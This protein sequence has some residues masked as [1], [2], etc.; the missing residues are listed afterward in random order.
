[1]HYID[2][3]VRAEIIEASG[4]DIVARNIQRGREQGVSGYNTWREI[5]G[6][7]PIKSFNKFGKFGNALKE[8]YNEPDDVDLFIGAML[9]KDAGFNVG[10]TFQ[11]LLG[12][13][14]QRIK[15]GDRFW[16]ERPC[17]IF[18]FTEG[19]RYDFS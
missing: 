4:S 10:P 19:K 14:Y 8:L 16:Y 7:E 3:N 5:C 13:Q 12:M 6:L 17:E 15:R 9:E 2:N 1:M 11:C 18:S